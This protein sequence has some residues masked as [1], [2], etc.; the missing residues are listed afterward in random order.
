MYS[1]PERDHS[2][3]LDFIASITCQYIHNGDRGTPMVIYMLV[4]TCFVAL[5]ETWHELTFSTM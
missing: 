2:I 3:E 5:P 1:I 4:I